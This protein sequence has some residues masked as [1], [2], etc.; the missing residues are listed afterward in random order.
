[1]LAELHVQRAGDLGAAHVELAPDVRAE[2]DHVGELGA[3]AHVEIGADAGCIHVQRAGD[4]GAAHVELPADLRAAQ[5]HVGE[6]GA[7]AH[8]ES[9]ADAGRIHVQRAGDLGA[10]H[11][12]LAR[13]CARRAGSRLRTRR[14]RA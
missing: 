2:Q 3:V 8:V 9:G 10:G 1:M 7:V 4:L 11:I 12:E 14:P 13:R 5:D 6:L